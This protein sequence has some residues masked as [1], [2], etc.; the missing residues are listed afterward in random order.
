MK[1][2]RIGL[3]VVVVLLVGYMPSH[4]QDNP[5][6]MAV[7][8]TTPLVN[9]NA[10]VINGAAVSLNIPADWGPLNTY[11]V[12]ANSPNLD[13]VV[14][15][16]FG[17]YRLAVYP[18]PNSYGFEGF[19]PTMDAVA[20]TEALYQREVKE[21]SSSYAI[22]SDVLVF[23]LPNGTY[24]EFLFALDTPQGV[25]IGATGFVRRGDRLIML[26]TVMLVSDVENDLST[27]LGFHATGR[28]IIDSMTVAP[29][30]P[31]Q[32]TNPGW[33]LDT[34]FTDEAGAISFQY[35]ERWYVTTPQPFDAGRATFDMG[36]FG[37]SS[38]IEI[39]FTGLLTDGYFDLHA[40]YAETVLNKLIQ[41][42][43]A[44]NYM[45]GFVE[46]SSTELM[47]GNYAYAEVVFSGLAE[48]DRGEVQHEERLYGLLDVGGGYYVY[49]EAT[50]IEGD[51]IQRAQLIPMTRAIVAT[52]T[53]NAALL[54][55]AVPF[56]WDPSAPGDTTVTSLATFDE[57]F[58]N[59]V[60][61]Y[62]VLLTDGYTGQ[63]NETFF[64]IFGPQGSRISLRFYTYEDAL[65][66][67]AAFG[68]VEAVL[69]SIV[70][71]HLQSIEPPSTRYEF[72]TGVNTF[73][74]ENGDYADVIF[75]QTRSDGRSTTIIWGILLIDGEIVSFWHE[76][77]SVLDLTDADILT[78]AADTRAIAA[79][80]L[81]EPRQ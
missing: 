54:A 63:T 69:A 46:V 20:A 15:P 13:G 53:F 66:E 49:I 75:R 73:A 57:P 77:P 47:L 81:L 31:G 42:I 27:F 61:R 58:S 62:G 45:A 22:R 33:A 26:W 55:P 65:I 5:D 80:F 44:Q 68:S 79:T 7:D 78:L 36:V 9:T 3:F 23:D 12:G 72:L 71:L 51:P 48:L 14:G 67:Q 50:V 35:P 29:A 74:F 52:F 28:A 39:D 59:V 34:T 30:E 19:E 10:D 21:V 41:G 1:L 2:L 8:T 76:I 16:P 18:L 70:P 37:S 25:L 17:I 38:G 64:Y 4:A 11:T 40:P 32:E 56:A 60:Y 6:L 24:A 43:V